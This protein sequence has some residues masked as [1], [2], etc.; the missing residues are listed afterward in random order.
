MFR[1]SSLGRVAAVAIATAILISGLAAAAPLGAQPVV[2]RLPGPRGD[3]FVDDGGRRTASRRYR[4]PLPGPV[5]DRFRL[6]SSP[7]GPGNRGWEYRGVAG[8]PLRAAGG[9]VVAFAGQVGGSL[10]VSIDHPDGLRTTYS[11]LSST[12]VRRGEHVSRG[13]IVGF[14]LDVVHFGVRRGDRYLDPALLFGRLHA[15]LVCVGVALSAGYVCG[16]EGR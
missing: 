16:S 10:V 9:G 14:A 4:P 6:P 1:R 11:W 7:Y 15:R 5:A 2:A 12:T 8:R 3:T 13:A